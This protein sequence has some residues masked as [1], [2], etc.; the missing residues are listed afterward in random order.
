MVARKEA[1]TYTY[2]PGL[3]RGPGPASLHT[4]LDGWTGRSTLKTAKN[5]DIICA[6]LLLLLLL[7]SERG[8]AEP[9]LSLFAVLVVFAGALCWRLRT[10]DGTSSKIAP[11]PQFIL[12]GGGGRNLAVGIARARLLA[13]C[14]QPV[15]RDD[16]AECVP[17]QRLVCFSVIDFDWHVRYA[18]VR[19]I[20]S[21]GWYLHLS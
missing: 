3:S 21:Y 2:T 12:P 9:S 13:Q 18:S 17:R 14:A 11:R 10:F 20:M 1:A 4:R 5:S 6:I 8:P 7:L 19:P 15:P 16:V